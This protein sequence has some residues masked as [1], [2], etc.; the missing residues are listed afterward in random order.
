MKKKKF[1]SWRKRFDFFWHFSQYKGPCF[2]E[3]V[4]KDKQTIFIQLSYKINMI[5]S[6]N[7]IGLP[8]LVLDKASQMM[9]SYL[10]QL[11]QLLRNIEEIQD[12]GGTIL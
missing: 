7:D 3:L 4:E 6:A 8:S 11:L 12:F 9:F 2:L 10:P 5:F 1:L